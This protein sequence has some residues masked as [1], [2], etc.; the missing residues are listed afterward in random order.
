MSYHIYENK[1]AGPHKAVIHHGS[2]GHCK[3]GQ[4]LN[5]GN[6]GPKHGKWHPRFDTLQEARKA[7]AEM[8]VKVR[9]EHRCCH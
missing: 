1:Q 8:S 4:G 3:D 7:Q 6:S 9:K 2:C 5:E